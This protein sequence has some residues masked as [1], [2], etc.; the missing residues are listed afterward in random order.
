M[1]KGQDCMYEIFSSR[2]TAACL[3]DRWLLVLGSSGAMNLA[4]AWMQA[5]DSV[6]TAPPF[7]GPRWYNWT[8]FGQ[9]SCKGEHAGLSFVNYKNMKVDM[10][11]DAR[12][13]V[14]WKGGRGVP[15][16]EA[17]Y[18]PGG[19]RLTA[20]GTAVEHSNGRI[21]PAA[22]PVRWNEDVSPPV[23]TDWSVAPQCFRRQEREVVEEGD[24]MGINVTELYAWPGYR[25]QRR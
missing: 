10:V 21:S 7:D 2:T 23:C 9:G 3:Q 4:L 22:S 19:W 17:L 16:E 5:L 25:R 13:R 8:C 12:G 1:P 18:A 20:L 24:P 14:L 11:F 15:L 6:G